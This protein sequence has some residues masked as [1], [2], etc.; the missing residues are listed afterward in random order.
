MFPDVLRWYDFYVD[1][2]KLFKRDVEGT[3]VVGA[4]KAKQGDDLDF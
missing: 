3:F 2:N 4:G 1:L